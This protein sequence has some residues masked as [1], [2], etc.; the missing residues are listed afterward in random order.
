M[1][2]RIDDIDVLSKRVD[3]ISKAVKEN[4]SIA[5]EFRKL[6]EFAAKSASNAQILDEHVV[7][8]NGGLMTYFNVIMEDLRLSSSATGGA[9]T[10]F[11]GLVHSGSSKFDTDRAKQEI[12]NARF[13][14][15]GEGFSSIVKI[16]NG[17][18][19]QGSV[20]T[21]VSEPGANIGLRITR[22]VGPDDP[23]G[24]TVSISNSPRN[25]K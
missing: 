25:R 3:L 9:T 18:F 23:G 12:S 17:L 16:Q 14:G 8:K 13:S 22:V 1:I 19:G 2:P 10:T 11:D 6:M 5:E 20:E 21:N 4:S 24:A 7:N 15:R